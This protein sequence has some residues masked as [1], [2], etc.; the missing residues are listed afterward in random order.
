MSFA[1]KAVHLELV[2]ELSTAAFTATLHRFIA[3]RGK[4]SALWSDHRTNCVGAVK[5]I[6][7]LYELLRKV[8]A[9]KKVSNFCSGKGIEWRFTPEGVPHFG[10][11]WEA[12]VKSFKYHLHQV[13]GDV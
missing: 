13:V 9:E 6:K 4:L 10:C 11:L 8:N 12:A 1:V 5:E 2:T 3:R 7:E